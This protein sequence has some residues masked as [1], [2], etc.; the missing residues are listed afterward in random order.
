MKRAALALIASV[1]TLW[2][3]APA[4]TV[5]APVHTSSPTGSLAIA[6]QQPS[7]GIAQLFIT[8]ATGT[9][10]HRVKLGYPIE[11]AGGAVWSPDGASILITN[12]LRFDGDRLLPFRPATV[13]GDGSSYK[14]LHIPGAP[15]DTFCDVWSP[16]GN[17]ILCTFGG[18]EPGIF[19]IRA[20][21]GR[22][23]VRLTRNP[24]GE[25]A[26]DVP[27]DFSPDGSQLVFVR[28]RPASSAHPDEGGALFVKDMDGTGSRRITSYGLPQW[29]EFGWAVHW[30]PDGREIVFGSVDGRLF[31]VHPDGTGLR[32]IHV[33]VGEQPYYAFSPG[34][35]PDGSRIVFSMFLDGQEDIYTAD[36][37]GTHVAQVTDTE[38]WEN[39]ADWTGP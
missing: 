28:V 5:A 26:S 11:Q 4:P 18:D 6:R 33:R 20:S 17:R 3:A 10:A 36:P 23:P 27:G 9:D 2:L 13:A 30:S 21:D 37:D 15:F 32:R 24:S 35:S 29:E 39:S 1:L 14:L 38:A 7:K 19:A 16:N 31:L 25:G 8:D 34:W 12:T 22:H